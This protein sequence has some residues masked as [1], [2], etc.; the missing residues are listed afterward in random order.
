M[1]MGST[2]ADDASVAVGGLLAHERRRPAS[3]SHELAF[4]LIAAARLLRRLGLVAGGVGSLMSP[5]ADRPQ[6]VL[7][8][9]TSVAPEQVRFRM[10]PLG[11]VVVVHGLVG[12][13]RLVERATGLLVWAPWHLTPAWPLLVP[14]TVVRLGTVEY[15][16]R[17]VPVPVP[18]LGRAGPAARARRDDYDAIAVLLRQLLGLEGLVGLVSAWPPA[19]LPAPAPV[20]TEPPPLTRAPVSP[21]PGF[22]PDVEAEAPPPPSRLHQ[23][24]LVGARWAVMVVAAV[25][26]SL[27]IGHEHAS[28]R[29]AAPGRAGPG[30]SGTAIAANPLG[31][32]QPV[33]IAFGGDVHFEGVLRRRLLSDPVGLLAPIRPVLASA[34]LTVANLETAI[35]ERGVR[36]VKQFNFRAPADGFRALR[37]AGVDV[38]SLA[39][40]HGL[41]Y[42]PEGLRDTLA[43]ARSA[44]L[45]VVGA[46]QDATEAYSAYRTQ[47]KGQRIAVIGAT[48]V[49]DNHLV[50]TW[51]APSRGWLRRRTSGA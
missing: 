48:Q 50:P 25:G 29:R 4:S 17:P 31:S 30:R 28:S 35:T 18:V 40:N 22:V 33:T 2:V 37:A 46:G 8:A 36:Q 1:T 11:E 26:V 34:D 42:G 39:N 23:A 38:V 15:V 16:W 45:A 49:I 7:A 43:A 14:A 19:H 32:G 10:E 21:P 12:R 27:G 6:L 41:D 13:P 24:A 9:P 20:L 44:G 5:V 3:P 47:I 51:T